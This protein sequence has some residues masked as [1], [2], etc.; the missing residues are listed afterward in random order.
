MELRDEG[1]YRLKRR[2]HVLT[3]ADTACVAPWPSLK[4]RPRST[5]IRARWCRRTNVSQQAMRSS[6]AQQTTLIE[7]AYQNAAYPSV[8]YKTAG[9]VTETFEA[10]PASQP[11]LMQAT[12]GYNLAGSTPADFSWV[13]PDNTQVPFALTDRNGP[14]SGDAGAGMGGVPEEADAKSADRRCKHGS[15]S[16]TGHMGLKLNRQIVRI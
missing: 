10:D 8:S 3:G 15:S 1:R 11:M 13:A 14:I 7:F 16:P 5:V 4:V 12:Q 9:G 2:H 6:Q